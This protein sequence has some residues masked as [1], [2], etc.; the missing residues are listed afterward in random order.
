MKTR[1]SYSTFSNSTAAN[2]LSWFLVL[3]NILFISVCLRWIQLVAVL[4]VVS[5]ALCKNFLKCFYSNTTHNNYH[6]SC[7]IFHLSE[8]LLNVVYLASS[9]IRYDCS[10]RH[11]AG[12]RRIVQSRMNI[13]ISCACG[14]TS[15]SILR[16]TAHHSCTLHHCQFLLCCSASPWKL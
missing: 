8:G 14:E 5:A 13:I 4:F 2:C 11:R 6:I 15:V 16:V 12:A 10:L 9:H 3:T 7:K 1:F